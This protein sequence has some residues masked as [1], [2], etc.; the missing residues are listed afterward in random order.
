MEYF[1]QE[2]KRKI[3]AMLEK[4]RENEVEQPQDTDYTHRLGYTPCAFKPQKESDDFI[5]ITVLTQE[6]QKLKNQY[7][8]LVQ[9]SIF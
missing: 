1:N 8:D 6:N 3:Q 4:Q 5:K 9:K 2:Q 7:F